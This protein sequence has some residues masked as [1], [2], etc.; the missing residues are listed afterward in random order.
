MYYIN[1]FYYYYYYYYGASYTH[2]DPPWIEATVPYMVA[3]KDLLLI[4]GFGEGGMFEK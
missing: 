4:V 1:V 2:T 3:A